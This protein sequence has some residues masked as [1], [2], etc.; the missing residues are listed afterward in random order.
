M[1]AIGA[2]SWES[3]SDRT[4]MLLRLVRILM[5]ICRYGVKGDAIDTRY[6]IERDV[7]LI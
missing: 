6:M 7:F 5:G 2:G 1:D 4:S 3:V